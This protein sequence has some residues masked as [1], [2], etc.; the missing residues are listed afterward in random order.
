MSDFFCAVCGKEKGKFTIVNGN[1]ICR[2]C[3]NEAK[4]FNNE[5]EAEKFLYNKMNES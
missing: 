1:C 3:W 5:K 2:D 4:K